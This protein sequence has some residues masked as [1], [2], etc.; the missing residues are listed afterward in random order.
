VWLLGQHL[1]A[2]LAQ[3]ALVLLPTEKSPPLPI[4]K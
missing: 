4:E 1:L 2:A 3:A